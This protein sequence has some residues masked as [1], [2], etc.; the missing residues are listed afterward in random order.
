[1]AVPQF[2]E[3]INPLLQA[4]HQ[5]GGS[6]SIPELEEA[7]VKILNLPEKDIN[8]IHRGNRTKFSYRLAWARYYLKKYG[9]ID[10]SIRGIWA[11]TTTGIRVTSVDKNEVVNKVKE[12][13]KEQISPKKETSEEIVEEEIVEPSW[14][15]ELLEIE[16]PPV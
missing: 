7:V 13:F 5:L 11:L 2:D 3:L 12:L 10:N 1:M 9:L 15:E 14:K 6:A 4:L 8:E 16:L